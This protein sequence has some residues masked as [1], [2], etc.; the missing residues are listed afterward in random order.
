MRARKSKEEI[1][2][3]CP[4]HIISIKKDIKGSVEKSS[5]SKN[6]DLKFYSIEVNKLNE[7]TFL[8]AIQI[9]IS[10]LV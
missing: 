4:F 6:N 1:F 2:G 3:E 10:L 7:F 5:D 8:F 9:N